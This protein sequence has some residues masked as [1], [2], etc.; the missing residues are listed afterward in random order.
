MKV[1]DLVVRK[2][3]ESEPSP[4]LRIVSNVVIDPLDGNYYLDFCDSSEGI[5]NADC[6]ILI[7]KCFDKH[8]SRN[9]DA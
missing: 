5:Q 6:W 3:T 2:L 1:G 7:S 8:E 4:D 9:S